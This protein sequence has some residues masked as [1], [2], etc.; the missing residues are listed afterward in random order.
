MTRI[1]LKRSNVLDTGKAKE[2]TSSQ[3]EMQQEIIFA[4]MVQTGDLQIQLTVVNTL[5]N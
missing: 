4:G 5:H 2:P 1:Q 3:M